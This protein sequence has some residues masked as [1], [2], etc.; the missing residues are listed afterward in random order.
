VG[1]RGIPALKTKNETTI[2]AEHAKHAELR[3]R[4]GRGV[5]QRDSMDEFEQIE[6]VDAL[7]QAALTEKYKH[8]PE[9]L[10]P[11][12]GDI[13]LGGWHGGVVRRSVSKVEKLSF[14]A[15]CAVP[16]QHPRC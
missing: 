13:R 9:V 8:S 12:F 7:I 6:R 16:V 11:P 1:E 15:T 2:N 10:N 5:D 3:K 4:Y 14:G